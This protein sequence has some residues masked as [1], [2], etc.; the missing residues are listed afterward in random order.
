MSHLAPTADDTIIWV[1][2]STTD[3]WQR[4]F[5]LNDVVDSRFAKANTDGLYRC[6][7]D[8]NGRRRTENFRVVQHQLQ[9]VS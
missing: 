9:P 6:E 3:G 1:E 4:V 2:H 8:R 5:L 7:I